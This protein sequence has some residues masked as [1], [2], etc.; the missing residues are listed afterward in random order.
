LFTARNLGSVVVT[1]APE[2]VP[3]GFIR[4][5]SRSGV[6]VCLGHTA[7][8]YEQTRAAL[9]EGASGFTH[10]FNAMTQLTSRE[11]GAVGAALEDPHAY[12]GVIVDGHHVHDASLRTALRAKAANRMMLVTDAM[13][14]VG[15][16]HK[17]FTLYGEEIEVAEGRCTTRSG[18]LAGSDLD[19]ATAVRNCVT[20]LHVPLAEA[21]R[22]ASLHP[23]TFLGLGAELGRVQPG[24]VA[25]LVW[26]DEE[27][28]VRGSW[29]GGHYASATDAL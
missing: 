3:G 22:M 2:C 18:T 6:R 19:M 4:E 29:I 7:A 28:R 11:P 14:C 26:L 9:R 21:L 10:L 5:L 8:S 23:A 15:A 13:P 20:R 16:A 1:V 12:C 17:S 24:Y 27:L 25:D